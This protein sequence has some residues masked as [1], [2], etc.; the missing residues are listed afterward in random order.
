MAINPASDL[1]AICQR[2]ADG[3]LRFS[4][5][6]RANITLFQKS[7]GFSV[8][9]KKYFLEILRAGSFCTFS[10]LFLFLIFIFTTRSWVF[11][12]RFPRL[13]KFG[14]F[15]KDKIAG[16]GGLWEFSPNI[17]ALD[18]GLRCINIASALDGMSKMV[19]AIFHY[20]LA[21]NRDKPKIRV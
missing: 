14:S 19:F 10:K 8:F 16:S 5:K 7:K 2:S 21:R 11:A 6:V 13:E 17:L 4:F 20:F 12:P 18:S 3:I 9:L 15:R 1:P